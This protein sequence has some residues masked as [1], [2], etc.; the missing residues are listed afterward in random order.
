MNKVFIFLVMFIN[1][2]C[3]D[4][5]EFGTKHLELEITNNTNSDAILSVVASLSRDSIAINVTKNSTESYY[6][7]KNPDLRGEGYYELRSGMIFSGLGYYTNGINL[8]P[9]G[10]PYT[11]IIEKDTI[12]TGL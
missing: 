11:I 1:V 12:I 5:D 8:Q 4:I 2:T 10:D 7:W 3:F 6:K 9:K